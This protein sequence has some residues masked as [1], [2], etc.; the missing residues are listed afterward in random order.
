MIGIFIQNVFC[1]ILILLQV[2]ELSPEERDKLQSN[3]GF[4]ETSLL[5]L[6][7]ENSYI[8]SKFNP[9]NTST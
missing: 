4:T 6:E 3:P 8:F 1:S 2:L 5:P 7:K 9:L